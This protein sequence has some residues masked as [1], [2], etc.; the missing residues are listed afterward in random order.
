MSIAQSRLIETEATRPSGMDCSQKAPALRV[1]LEQVRADEH[2][3]SRSI[4]D[5]A[6]RRIRKT[7]VANLLASCGV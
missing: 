3:D 4:Y 2:P 7:Y 6:V 5:E 1:E